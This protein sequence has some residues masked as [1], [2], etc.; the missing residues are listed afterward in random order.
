MPVG[1][2]SALIGVI[3]V[4]GVGWAGSNLPPGNWFAPFSI[5]SSFNMASFLD[6]RF[7]GDRDADS[8][9]QKLGHYGFERFALPG[10]I[11]GFV[12]LLYVGLWR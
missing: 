7:L 11:F 2:A 5:P 8:C 6:G 12:G 9:E 4:A 10:F 1:L 3:L